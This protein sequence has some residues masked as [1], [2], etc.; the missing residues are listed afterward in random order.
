LAK[1]S[2]L[3]SA[4]ASRLF[5]GKLSGAERMSVGAWSEVALE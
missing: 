2:M 5:S 3:G 4:W 1:E